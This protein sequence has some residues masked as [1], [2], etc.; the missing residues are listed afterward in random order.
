[1][2]RGIVERAE[3]V[4]V[5]KADGE[6]AA[7]SELAVAE[8]RSALRLLRQPSAAWTPEVWPVSAMTGRGLDTIW[9]AVERHRLALG[10]TGA[11]AQRRLQQNERALWAE[12]GQLLLDLG[13]QRPGMAAT[14]AHIE[15]AVRDGAMTP[16]A[17]ARD[18][19]RRVL[20]HG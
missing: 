10:G 18:L 16:G 19:V 4:L 7:A 12:F 11:L 6:T 2:K 1:L 5:T 14:I 8:Y 13:R 17:G 15:A 20:G 9:S 3:L